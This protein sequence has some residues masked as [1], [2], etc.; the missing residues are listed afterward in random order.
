MRRVD[1]TADTLE[2]HVFYAVGSV[3]TIWKERCRLYVMVKFVRMQVQLCL[4]NASVRKVQ[5]IFGKTSVNYFQENR[6]KFRD[7][8]PAVSPSVRSFD[9]PP[10]DSKSPEPKSKRIGAIRSEVDQLCYNIA[11]LLHVTLTTPLGIRFTIYQ[12]SWNVTH[13]DDGLIIAS[14]HSESEVSYGHHYN[15]YVNWRWY[16]RRESICP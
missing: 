1:L 16:R 12:L 3:A 13:L 7:G 2:P 5:K 9:P 4:D 10:T 14:Y 6:T 15:R 11:L 8:L